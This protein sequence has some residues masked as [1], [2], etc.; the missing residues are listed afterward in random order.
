M[1]ERKKKH[2]TQAEGLHSSKDPR[3]NLRPLAIA[4]EDILHIYSGHNGGSSNNEAAN[5]LRSLRLAGKI[6]KSER[7]LTEVLAG[8]KL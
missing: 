3:Y 5:Q 8:T 2:E 4:V 1:H 6:Q 7:H